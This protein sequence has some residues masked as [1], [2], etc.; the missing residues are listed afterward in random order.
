MIPLPS[1][2]WRPF[3]VALVTVG[4]LTTAAWV[5]HPPVYFTND[6][7]T[8]RLALEGRAFPGQ[9][10][11]GFVLFITSPLAWGLVA[12]YRLLP[13]IPWWDLL[14]S[15]TLI[16]ALATFF[17]VAWSSLGP[18]WLA[19]AT[20]VGVVLLVAA[21][22]VSGLQYT[23]AA[24]L[25]AGASVLIASLELGTTFAAR[26]SV[27]AMAAALLVLALIMRPMGAV[28]GIVAVLL[29][30]VPLAIFGGL[31]LQRVA[32]AL[33]AV[34]V[35]IAGVVLADISLYKL[36]D[37]WDGYRRYN[38]IVLR[39]LEW[40]D[41]ASTVEADSIRQA[42]G[43]SSNDWKMIR[44]FAVDPNV[45]GV[46]HIAKAYETRA[47]S[48]GWDRVIRSSWFDRAGAE[49]GLRR[50]LT[51]SV[52]ALSGIAALLLAFGT[53][54]SVAATVALV[55][56]FCALCIGTEAVFKELP[57]RVL[58]PMQLCMA[59]AAVA[60]AGT[61][62]GA[63]R[64]PRAVL[65]LGILVAIVTF[66]IPAT[67]RAAAA[68][69]DHSRQVDSEVLSL[70]RLSPSLVVLHSDTFP[71]EHWW[72]P[73][74]RPPIDLPAIVLSWNNQNPLLQRFLSETGRLPLLRAICADQSILV[75]ADEGR[76]DFVTTYL[77]EHFN[78]SVAWTEVTEASLSFP[79]WRCSVTQSGDSADL[80]APHTA[81]P[82]Q[83][84][85]TDST[86]SAMRAAQ[87]K[88]PHSRHALRRPSPMR[89]V[90]RGASSD[91]IPSLRSI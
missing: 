71:R 52:L 37:R 86:D 56:A 51:E 25:A 21:P 14:V 19:R 70:A 33:A 24:T 46:V 82:S 44:W 9:P 3:Q 28:G 53:R 58:A 13:S 18:G 26:R 72:R 23:I 88:I 12:A 45:H 68:E 42:V 5:L 67:L 8:I 79:V 47:A 35:L 34:A 30:L 36:D 91:T 57:F 61:L 50:V 49:G 81:V 76:L 75:V 20:S 90:P 54:R 17:A 87:S 80:R 7:V 66:Q 73:F 41:E 31:R 64:P 10:P 85:D 2:Q 48:L 15:G 65:G 77:Q 32:L 4:V 69:R 59:A 63:P 60:V 40:G 11:T 62:R 78:T 43:W 27:L 6:D 74:R 55:A 1:F 89:V 29:C 84:A 22:L 39:L 16:W 83:I 38:S